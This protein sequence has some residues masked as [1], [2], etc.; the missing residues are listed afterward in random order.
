MVYEFMIILISVAH[1]LLS[2]KDKTYYFIDYGIKIVKWYG[3]W[4]RLNKI[5]RNYNTFLWLCYCKIKNCTQDGL[6]S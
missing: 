1:Q 3:Q 6:R 2:I 4:I 5:H